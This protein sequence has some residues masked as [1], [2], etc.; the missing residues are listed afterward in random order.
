MFSSTNAASTWMSWWSW[1]SGQFFD[2]W[3]LDG[4]SVV[5][6]GSFLSENWS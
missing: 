3:E 6:R 1:W 2:P 5:Y 4:Y